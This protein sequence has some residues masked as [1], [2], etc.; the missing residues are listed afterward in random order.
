MLTEP[1]RSRILIDL[2][3]LKEDMEDLLSRLKNIVDIILKE[4]NHAN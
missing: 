3:Y 2:S 1:D 4:N